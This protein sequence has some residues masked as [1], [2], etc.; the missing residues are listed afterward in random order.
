MKYLLNTVTKLFN[1]V[2][3]ACNSSSHNIY[4]ILIGLL[5]NLRYL[6]M[7]N[8]TRSRFV[9]FSTTIFRS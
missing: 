8:R 3:V 2:S 6:D 5:F 1:L 7:F 9:D 4:V